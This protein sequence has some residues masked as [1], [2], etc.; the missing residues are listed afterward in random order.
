LRLQTNI[1]WEIQKRITTMNQTKRK[2]CGIRASSI[3]TF[4]PMTNS[5]LPPAGFGEKYNNGLSNTRPR[6]GAGRTHPHGLGT[7]SKI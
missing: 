3:A 6:K 4:A 1:D 7:Q 2:I 5:I